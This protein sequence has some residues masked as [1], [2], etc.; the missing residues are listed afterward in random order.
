MRKSGFAFLLIIG[1]S[2]VAFAQ[3][4]DDMYYNSSDRKKQKQNRIKELEAELRFLNS[5]DYSFIEDTSVNE[6]DPELIGAY[7]EQAAATR[8]EYQ[9]SYNSSNNISNSNFGEDPLNFQYDGNLNDQ[10]YYE[11]DYY[12][13]QQATIINNYYG[14]DYQRGYGRYGYN[15]FWIPYGSLAGW[16]IGTYI[17]MGG[18]GS[19]YGDPFYNRYAYDPWYYNSWNNGYAYNSNWGNSWRAYRTYYGSGYGLG[20][21]AYGGY[22]GGEYYAKNTPSKRAKRGVTRGARTNRGG[23]VTGDNGGG[24]SVINSTA[25]LSD[26]RNRSRAQQDYLKKSRSSKGRSS[27]TLGS[28]QGVTTLNSNQPLG[29]TKY[30]RGS[31]SA[32]RNGKGASGSISKKTF[33]SGNVRPSGSST[34][35]S[36][37]SYSS[38]RS[39]NSSNTQNSSS[40]KPNRSSSSSSIRSNTNRSSNSSYKPTNRSSGGASKSSSSSYKPSS[41]SRSSGSSSRSGGST[42]SSSSSKSRSSSGR[43]K[44]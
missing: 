27:T 40:V 13:D 16:S 12:D 20:Y 23:A 8:L 36:A 44:N 7:Q 9:S 41:S 33:R 38:P 2:F 34:R 29:R 15:S 14:R 3:E 19:F 5:E 35:G 39:G 10:Y 31:S 17:G 26:S 24:S 11:D 1:F 18:F 43:K 4:N 6:V 37:R 30:S 42:R 32:V 28:R 25:S 21:G 22:H